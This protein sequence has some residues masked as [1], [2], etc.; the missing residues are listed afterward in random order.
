MGKFD[1]IDIF[2]IAIISTYF[3]TL[4]CI[5][6]TFLF[7]WLS[8]REK[9]STKF[10][11]NMEILKDVVEESVK[12]KKEKVRKEKVKREFNFKDR[13]SS[14]PLFRKLFMKEVK[15]STNEVGTKV[16]DVEK[17]K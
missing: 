1:P 17:V 10:V 5:G 4:I 6:F 13:M 15:N 3:I 16:L 8:N 7:M 14:I 12:L 2:F 9:K 11:P